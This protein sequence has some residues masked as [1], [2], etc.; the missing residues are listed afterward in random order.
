MLDPF[1]VPNAKTLA[2]DDDFRISARK[3]WLVLDQMMPNICAICFDNA[4][5]IVFSERSVHVVNL[6]M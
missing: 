3:K 5:N 2:F 1:L 4:A 6:S